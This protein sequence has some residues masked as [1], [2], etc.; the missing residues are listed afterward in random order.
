MNEKNKKTIIKKED[1]P[2]L[3]AFFVVAAGVILFVLLSNISI[4]LALLD[5]LMSVL[6]P[7]IVGLC[8]AFVLNLPLRFIENRLFGRLTRKNGKIWSKLKRPVCLILSLLLVLS[9]I[10]LLLSFVIPE[11]VETCKKFFAALPAAM[12]NISNSI[13]SML[14]HFN[15]HGS[16][17]RFNIDWKLISSWALDLINNSEIGITQTAVEIITGLFS[18][19]LNF[20]LGLVFSIYILAS[21]EA[22]GRLMKSLVYSIMKRERAKKLISL[23]V[24]SNKAFSGFVAGQCIEVLLIGVLCFVGMLIFKMPYAIMVSCVIA[25]TAFI[26]VFGPF[27]GTAIGAFLILVESPIKALWFI[28]FIIIL[29]QLESNIIYPKIMGKHVGLPGIWVLIAVTIGGGLFGV[30]G[31]I[32][33]VPICS[34]LYALFDKWIKKRLKERNICHRSMSHDSSEP[35]SLIEEMQMMDFEDD[36]GDDLDDDVYT[37]EGELKHYYSS[38]QNENEQISSDDNANIE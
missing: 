29:Q 2:Y 21:K 19:V 36:I 12:E 15:L 6:T 16:E 24:M 37:D 22:L 20:I 17:E 28:V 5:K 8:F 27:I 9:V 7:L 34:V 1:H 30:V 14:V 11:F 26:P 35:K 33:S 32:V 4:V 13:N 23:V 38:A 31:I 10:V 3:K 25:F 18:T